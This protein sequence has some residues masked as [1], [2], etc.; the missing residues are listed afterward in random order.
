M[1]YGRA[2]A[3]IGFAVG[4]GALVL[5]FALTVPAAME[6]RSLPLALVFFFSF[7]TILSNLSLVLVYLSELAPNLPLG[8][9][10]LP[11]V[12]GMMVAVMA[13]VL[14]FYHFL[15]AGSWDPQGP[16]LVADR[17]LHYATPLIYAIWWARFVQHGS[18]KFTDLPAMLLPTL[19][20]FLL[21]LLRG[22]FV[23]EYPYF[24]LEVERLGYPAVLLNALIVAAGLAVLSAI[25]IA[26]DHLL[27][28]P[29]R[30]N[31]A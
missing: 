3:A 20:Y 30:T 26:I 5:Q 10:R 22:L 31:L 6:T 12:R 7:F 14:L 16:Y 23:A 18:L 28:R 13:L 8:V 15:L 9:F 29:T 17:L 27:A 1:N 11:R 24:I 19:V 2:N 25:V 21:I 4:L